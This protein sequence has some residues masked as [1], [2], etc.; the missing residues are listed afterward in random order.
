MPCLP[1]CYAFREGERVR[2]G[3][4]EEA[5]FALPHMR[6]E[7]GFPTPVT[8]KNPSRLLVLASHESPF[9]PLKQPLREQGENGRR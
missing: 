6:C 9:Q 3:K 4:E 5:G 8:R 2:E 1:F 7:A